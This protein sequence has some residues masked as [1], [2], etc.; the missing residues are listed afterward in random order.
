MM[1][2]YDVEKYDETNKVTK[3]PSKYFQHHLTVSNGFNGTV[4]RNWLHRKIDN[5]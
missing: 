4:I 5:R 2:I 1:F 3:R